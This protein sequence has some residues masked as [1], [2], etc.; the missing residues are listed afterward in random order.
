MSWVLDNLLF[1]VVCSKKGNHYLSNFSFVRHTIYEI[2]HYLL[3]LLLWNMLTTAQNGHFWKW[4]T[5]V[6]VCCKSPAYGTRTWRGCSRLHTFVHRNSSHHSIKNSYLLSQYYFTLMCI[7]WF[8]F[9]WLITVILCE[10]LN[11][12]TVCDGHKQKK[13]M[14]MVK[15]QKKTI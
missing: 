5:A 6:T 2:V 1:L 7:T 4:G 10:F 14:S 9:F 13:I 15:L 11:Y 8:I 3:L 12:L